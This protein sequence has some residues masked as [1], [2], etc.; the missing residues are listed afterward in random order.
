[1]ETSVEQSYQTRVFPEKRF[2]NFL[3]LYQFPLGLRY[4][5]DGIFR[6]SRSTIWFEKNLGPD[7]GEHAYHGVNKISPIDYVRCVIFAKKLLALYSRVCSIAIAV[8]MWCV[9][10]AQA[11]ASNIGSYLVV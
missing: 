3:F 8:D 10:N 6:N 9:G 1:M 4:D 11:T 5:C 7:E 2:R